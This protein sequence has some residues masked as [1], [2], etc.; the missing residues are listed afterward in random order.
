MRAARKWRELVVAAALGC[1]SAFVGPPETGAAPSASG[2]DAG[3]DVVL[4]WNE[5]AQG[6]IGA[7]TPNPLH[8][9][10]FFAIVSA[11]VYDGVNSVVRSHEPYSGFVETPPGASAEA[12][13]VA[14]A[15]HALVALFPSASS[16][17]DQAY[18]DSLAEHGLS[19]TDPGVAVGESASQAVLDARA[20][21]G[22][23]QAQFP[24][25]PPGAGQPGVWVPAPPGFAPAFLP[26]WGAT[27]TW[28]LREPAQFRPEEG[29]PAL[30]TEE[31]A[32]ELNEVK[33]VGAADSPVRTAEQTQI[34]LF[35]R[36]SAPVIW[37]PVARQVV[38]H[39]GLG[40]ADSARL[41]A[42][43]NIAGA[44]ASIAC[45]DAKYAFNTWR[46][47]TAIRQADTDGN[48]ATVADPGWTPLVPTP[49]FP[50]FTSGHTT[51]SAALAGVLERSFGDPGMELTA[52]SP[53]NPGFVRHWSSFREGVE[54]VVEARIVSGIHFRT[55]DER[56]AVQGRQVARFVSTHSLRERVG[57]GNR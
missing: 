32:A 24:Y 27:E 39:R 53:L 47:V 33:L 25:T 44:D 37:N 17:L 13:A 21:D 46:P 5:I 34:A 19:P 11:A 31:Y 23:A 48:P 7:S 38:A 36:A 20:D 56:G 12:A 10:R 16:S 22:A 51:I 40:L 15:H 9:Q 35:W 43:M 57:G 8:H 41:F 3:A 1:S 28:S 45:W 42:L 14:A 18:A 29:P 50:E 55:G 30:S 4:E 2:A 49:A 26:G 54:E 6:A 52:T